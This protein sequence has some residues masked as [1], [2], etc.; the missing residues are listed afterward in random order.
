MKL[1]INRNNDTL[2]QSIKQ[3]NPRLYEA[4]RKSEIV[5]FDLYTCHGFGISGDIAV[6]TDAFPPAIITADC[7]LVKIFVA[8][9]VPPAGSDAVLYVYKGS[10]SCGILKSNLSFPAGFTGVKE[11]SEFGI[12]SFKAGETLHGNLT[13]VGSTTAGTG[14]TVSFLFRL[15]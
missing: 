6:D 10:T 7:E 13:Q 14:L 2:I 3:S 8:F 1:T 12:T 5:D 9:R 15:V 4:L 11:F